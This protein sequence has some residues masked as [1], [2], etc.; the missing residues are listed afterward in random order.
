MDQYTAKTEQDKEDARVQ[1][2][3]FLIVFF[4]FLAGLTIAV[5][6][7]FHYSAEA[8]NKRTKTS[9]PI[10]QPGNV[11]S[12]ET[13]N[14][15]TKLN[16]TLR[17]RINTQKNTHTQSKNR[18]SNTIYYKISYINPNFGI[19][20]GE[21]K[22]ILEKAESIWEK[23]SGLNLFEYN[24]AKAVLTIDFVYDERQKI[25]QTTNSLKALLAE[26]DAYYDLLKNDYNLALANYQNNNSE[27]NYNLLEESRKKLDEA[28]N[29]FNTT[30]DQI[31]ALTK[32]LPENF[33]LGEYFSA[34][35]NEPESIKIYSYGNKLNLLST[36]THE[37]GHALGMEHVSGRD[38]ILSSI[39]TTS[40]TTP[41]Q[42]DINEFNRVCKN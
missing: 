31:N 29:S 37:L 15:T 19:T 40:P 35:E 22:N 1:P 26:Q 3:E 34:F 6:L 17:D 30:N 25:T 33:I 11:L 13:T 12:I 14:P 24:E 41:S 4:K 27:E 7:V 38:S 36:L 42:Q 21:V 28:A 9:S 5:L 2:G 18:C 39:D 8:K 23:Q 32:K 10:K 16:P 20:T